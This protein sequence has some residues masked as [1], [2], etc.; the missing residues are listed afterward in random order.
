MKIEKGPGVAKNEVVKSDCGRDCNQEEKAIVFVGCTANGKSSLIQS[1]LKYGGHHVEADSVEVGMGN[2]S[3]T[4][5]VSSFRFTVDIKDH[6]LKDRLG[7]V[8]AAVDEDTDIYALEP[9]TS[10]SGRHVH[11][12]MLDTPGLDDSDNLKE[13]EERDQDGSADGCP[14]MRT[15]DERHKFAVLT[16]LGGLKEVHSVCFVI[17]LDST[18]NPSAQRVIKEY[19]EMF[20][21]SDLD[22]TYHFAHTFIHVENMFDKKAL[23]RPQVIENTFDIRADQAKHHQIDNLP[24]KD[25]PISKHFADRAISRLIDSLADGAGQPTTNMRYPLSDAHKIMNVDINQSLQVL[26]RSWETRVS[27][28]EASLSKLEKSK[29]P[30]NVKLEVQ[31]K[32]WLELHLH[33]SQFDTEE[34]VE[35]G[36][37]HMSE[38]SHLTSRTKL[39]FRVTAKAPIRSWKLSDNGGVWYG[40]G[41]ITKGVD[42]TCNVRLEA[43]Y[44]DSAAGSV[45]LL[46]WK[47]EAFK[48]SLAQAEK[49]TNEAKTEYEDTKSKI[50]AFEEQI[51]DAKETIEQMQGDIK[52]LVKQMDIL[53]QTDYCSLEEIMAHGAFLSVPDVCCYLLDEQETVDFFDQDLLPISTVQMSE[54]REDY[55]NE[56]AEISDALAFCSIMLKA[57]DEDLQAK[58]M[59]RDEL[60]A[61]RITIGD[62][63]NANE[64]Q[65]D[66]VREAGSSWQNEV[67]DDVFLDPVD[68]REV[69]RYVEKL[70]SELKQRIDSGVK[71]VN[72]AMGQEGERLLDRATVVESAIKKLDAL[73]DSNREIQAKW[74]VI[75]SDHQVSLE[76]TKRMVEVASGETLS[77][78]Q[79]T[80]LRKGIDDFGPDSKQPWKR[81]F[82]SFR[83]VEKCKRLNTKTAEL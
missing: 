11:L 24:I 30:L 51:T 52:I 43:A 64:V 48:E 74:K 31:I 18:L 50:N 13:D 46:G 7:N 37:A 55:T 82:G 6:I 63:L 10:S 76:A 4:K 62:H 54:I 34:L 41:S 26:Q 45:T 68:R 77:V 60:D 3:T 17:S 72:D 65:F 70:H 28:L 44:G 25:D 53:I 69:G 83:D 12:L 1:I 20:K 59:V 40:F 79:F 15:V 73:M 57:L 38:R 80:V 66:A 8:V 23:N 16:A 35:V 42:K 71:I 22:A 29:Q 67:G 61:V 81:L 33:A 9:H 27:Q 39:Y 36:Y 2:K 58:K 75:E 47:K 5:T 49:A 32:N 56:A 21:K 19:L 78:G 14:Q